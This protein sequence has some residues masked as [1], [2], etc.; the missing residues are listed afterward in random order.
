MKRFLVIIF[1]FAIFSLGAKTALAGS[2]LT[3]VPP[4]DFYKVGNSVPITINIKNTPTNARKINFYISDTALFDSFSAQNHLKASFTPPAAGK[5][6]TFTYTWDTA[7]A[8]SNAGEHYLTAYLLDENGK[9]IEREVQTYNLLGASGTGG[10][11]PSPGTTGGSGSGSGGG[12]TGSG[13]GSGA[14]SGTTGGS[15]TTAGGTASGGIGFDL[16]K[17]GKIN[18][19]SRKVNSAEDLIV[20]IINWLLG[21]M[22]ALAV[23][24]IIYSGLMYITAGADQTKAE[25]AKKN[26]VWAIIGVVIVALSFVIVS[27]IG[28]I[29]EP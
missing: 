16:G 17:L 12:G 22:G 4:F 23:I 11:G 15:G 13:T 9:E 27:W 6:E 18:F 5:E 24:A 19:T 20:V 7:A 14:N 2:Y 1:I 29:I 25:N 3:V 10:T 8:Q 21:L 26:L 28:Q